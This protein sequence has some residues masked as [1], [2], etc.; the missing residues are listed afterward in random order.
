MKIMMLNTLYS[1]NVV[2]GAEIIFQEQ[3]EGFA[4]L[5]NEVI[6]VTTTDGNEILWEFKN[7]VKVCRIPIANI[8]WHY[9]KDKAT[10]FAH[11][12]W[13]LLDIYNIR[14][15]QVLLNIVNKVN[16]DIA[17][18][19]NLAGFSISVWGV[20]KSKKIPLIQV[21]HDQ[22]LLC[23][24][25]NAFK[26]GRICQKQCLLC[27]LMRLPHKSASNQVDAV[28]GVSKYV[29]DR[30]VYNGYFRDSKK[31]I[32]RNARNF[33][34][35]PIPR[36]WDGKS[37]LKIGYIGTLSKVKGVEWLIKTFMSLDM[38]ATLIIAGKGD[39][40][41]YE[42]YLH[43]LAASDKRIQFTEYTKPENHY[44]N[45]HLSVIP[46]LWPDT[47]PTVAFESCAYHV[48]VIAT[49]VGG[50]P[51]IIKEGVNGWLIDSH[52]QYSLAKK[53]L[54]IYAHPNTLFKMSQNTKNSVENFLSIEYMI[55]KYISVMEELK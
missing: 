31:Y 32:I 3:A 52:N 55:K 6:V 37:P 51:E 27:H 23:P 33:I 15:K 20:F 12:I 53:M 14:M 11:K 1:P 21:L 16:P 18:C 2:G 26:N 47:L 28:V 19:H 44:T 25:S 8:Y 50:L 54:D 46:S 40:P 38:N 42:N 45:I 17:V 5:G 34:N 43:H 36:P 39:T 9:E 10:K 49:N 13:H 41:V 35:I 22:Y 7:G 29:L 48:P 4:K 24:N 30:L